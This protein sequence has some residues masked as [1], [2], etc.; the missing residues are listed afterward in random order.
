VVIFLNAF[1]FVRSMYVNELLISGIFYMA[2]LLPHL[3]W[4]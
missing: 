4:V 3:C 1:F 2:V